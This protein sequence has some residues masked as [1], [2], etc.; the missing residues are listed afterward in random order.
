MCKYC[1]TNTQ[2]NLSQFWMGE[3][4]CDTKYESCK[5][6]RK[7]DDHYIY[8]SGSYEDYSELISYCPFC[9]KKLNNTK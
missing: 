4:I 8:L 9:G 3:L 2:D 1:E 5:I 6:V 7:N